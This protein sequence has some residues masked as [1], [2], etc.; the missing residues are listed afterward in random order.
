MSFAREFMRN[1]R[2]SNVMR[3]VRRQLE[4]EDL[5]E[6]YDVEYVISHFDY[7]TKEYC[8]TSERLREMAPGCVER[9]RRELEQRARVAE[10]AGKVVGAED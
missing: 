8:F 2:R 5:L 7:V 3:D 4:V 6:T 1:A 9:K 10:L